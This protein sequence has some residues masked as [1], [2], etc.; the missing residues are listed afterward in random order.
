MEIVREEKLIEQVPAKTA[1]LV[2]GL[3]RLATKHPNTIH[4]IRGTG[5]YQGFSVRGAGVAGRL[6]D[7]ALQ[8]ESMLLLS[9]GPASIRLRPT[10]SVTEA[11]ID[12]LIEKLDRCLARLSNEP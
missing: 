6:V 12:R 11:D 4:N 7:M 5:L 2:N 10:L 9:A 8:Q 3:C 1:R